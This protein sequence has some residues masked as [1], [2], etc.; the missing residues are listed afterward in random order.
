[1]RSDKEIVEWLLGHELDENNCTPYCPGWHC[2]TSVTGDNALM[3]FFDDE[4]NF[5][6]FKCHHQSC[7]PHRKMFYSAVM[8][9]IRLERE[10]AQR[11]L[12]LDT[13]EPVRPWR[14]LPAPHKASGLVHHAPPKKSALRV[15]DVQLHAQQYATA[16]PVNVTANMLR[17][18]S[19]VPIPPTS[20]M[21]EWPKLML[22]TLYHEG[23]HIII[24]DQPR[25][26]GTY[27]YVVGDGFYQLSPRY[28]DNSRQKLVSCLV[29]SLQ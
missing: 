20:S 10:A 26:F 6:G 17:A 15:E 7:E 28:G 9:Q 27:E 4:G 5:T 18:A 8:S 29:S 14:I 25:S 19:P 16:C 23:E 13:T 2:H 11:H 1:M 12:R 24:F 3:V 22:D 21:K